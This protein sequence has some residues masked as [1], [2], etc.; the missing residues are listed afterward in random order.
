M[1]FI[2]QHAFLLLLACTLF[3]GFL[4]AE[5]LR[6]I[7]ELEWLKW[8]I[9]LVTMFAMAWPLQ[10]GALK[11][12]VMSPTP[13]M[14]AVFVNFVIVPFIAWPVS[15]LFSPEIA[16]GIM[17]ACCGPTTLATGPVWT[18]RAGGD[19]NVAMLVTILCNG[20]CFIVTPLLIFGLTGNE[21]PQELFYSTVQK[22]L[23]F[24]VLPIF[25]AQILRLENR[26]ATWVTRNKSLFGK[27]AQA[28]VLF[29]TTLGA[30]QTGLRMQAS[31]NSTPQTAEAIF[32]LGFMLVAVLT[33]HVGGFFSA[34]FL[35]RRF[36]LSPD[37]Q[38]AVGISGSQ[39]TMMVGLS[40]AINL[41]VSILPMIAYHALQLVVDTFFADRHRRIY[42]SEPSEQPDSSKP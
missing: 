21:T 4:L 10:F 15:K 25:F 9:V 24:V 35:A 18:R 29:M 32:E 11:R 17:V 16:V 27:I 20:L 26:S 28:G 8:A 1:S 3:F 6:P 36:Q 40:I 19:D 12:A 14:L 13:A 5:A 39:K 23:L 38:I 2:R 41:G 30:V 7:A 34:L 37:K 31:E 42:V 33:I 22:L